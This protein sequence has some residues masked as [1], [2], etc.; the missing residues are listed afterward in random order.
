MRYPTT[1][2]TSE[3]AIESRNMIFADTTVRRSEVILSA[4]TAQ[5]RRCLGVG[6][7]GTGGACTGVPLYRHRYTSFISGYL[8]SVQA[9]P[10]PFTKERLLFLSEGRT[11]G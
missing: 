3:N 1:T 8:I 4:G 10:H 7:T 6:D 9:R 11:V 2:P 5:L